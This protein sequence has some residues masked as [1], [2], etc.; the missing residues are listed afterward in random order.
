M[1]Y[2]VVVKVTAK[3]KKKQHQKKITK[4]NQTISLRKKYKKKEN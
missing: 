2:H 1:D 4:K 3:E